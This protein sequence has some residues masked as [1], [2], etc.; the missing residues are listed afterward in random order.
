M[1]AGSDNPLSANSE[2]LLLA[3]LTVTFPPAAVSVPVAVPVLPTVTLP[4]LNVVGPTVNCVVAAT[5]V[6]LRSATVV[7]G[8]ALLE[9]VSV[10]LVAPL[11]CG[12]KLTVKEALLPSAIV[13]G[14]DRPL[15]A[16]LELLQLAEVMVTLPDDA[17]SVPVAVPLPPTL[18]LPKLSVPGV[19]ANLEGRKPMPV[20]LKGIARVGFE[21]FDVMA[22]LPLAF[23]EVLGVNTTEKCVL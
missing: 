5:P 11:D 10:A 13:T 9:K 22:T 19:I 7:G 2:L 14:S 12:W 21:A 20:A 1:T 6:P 4:R 15:N 23:A 3:E 8:E 18:T 17:V 16:K